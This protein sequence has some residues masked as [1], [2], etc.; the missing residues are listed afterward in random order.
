MK[1]IVQKKEER[2]GLVVQMRAILDKAETE[3]R[4]LSAE[5]DAQYRRIEADVD[6]LGKEIEAEERSGRLGNLENA[7]KPP[8]EGGD[9]R[10]IAGGA[11]EGEVQ[12][13]AFR[14]FLLTGETRDLSIGTGGGAL[15]PQQFIS[16]VISGIE[17]MTFM[18][19]AATVYQIRG[20]Q[21]LG[22]PYES[23]GASDAAWT[24]EVP[25]EATAGD[26]TWAFAKREIKPN[27]LVKLVKLSKMLV[28]QSALPIESIV[29]AKLAEKIGSAYE[30]GMLNGS[31]SGQPLG[32][33]TAS[34]N[35]IATSRDV[36]TGNTATEITFDGLMSAM[37]S[38]RPGYRKN[39][40]WIFHTDALL[41]LR[42][43]KGT[44]GQYVWNPSVVA[45][46]PDQILGH[47]FRE[48]EF[49]PNTFTTGLYVGAFGDLKKYWIAESMDLEV[50]RLVERYAEF[51]Q[52]GFLGTMYAD[53]AP[54]IGEAFSRVKLA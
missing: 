24:A 26:S 10:Q 11:G 51:N 1:T 53:G 45:G 18:R 31:G 15:S 9:Q 43:I 27:T 8:L 2:M 54:V 46:I 32:I 16:D 50:Q 19:E 34:A 17:K 44:D 42:K 4:T 39:A 5:E 21:S 48:S 28:K 36:S 40:S 22:V 41:K 30:N 23:A 13:A 38:V 33:F 35:G 47:G 25:A 20:A 6:T 49:A 52:V 12:E 14:N 7:L 3:K 29:A 37:M